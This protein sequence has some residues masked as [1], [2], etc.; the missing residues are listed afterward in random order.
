[1]PS[2]PLDPLRAPVPWLTAALIASAL[3]AFFVGRRSAETVPSASS[4]VITVSPSPNVILAVRELARLETM[5]YHVERV[6][7]LADEQERLFGLVHAKDALLLVAAG[8]VV[9]GVDL[10]KLSDADF[11]VDWPSR[12]AHV[13]LPEPEI[14]AVTIDN[15]RTHVVTRSTDTL[16]TRREELEGHARREAETTMR[17]AALEAGVLPRAKTAAARAVAELLRGL[18]FTVIIFE[19]EPAPLE[20]E[21]P[22]RRATSSL[23]DAD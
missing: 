14:F 5:D 3:A 21:T 16:A 12:R 22:A 7:E 10:T 18:G 9:A 20:G 17:Q 15:A 11:T 6:I 2:E 8:D 23:G 13:R 1:V 19:G 4:S